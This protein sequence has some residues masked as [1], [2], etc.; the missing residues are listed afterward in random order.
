LRLKI[1]KKL[2]TANLNS[3]FPGS[4]KKSVLLVVFVAYN[5]YASLFAVSYRIYTGNS[6]SS[7]RLFT[8]FFI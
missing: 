7:N 3:E 2:G 8:L 1:L 5:R 4:Y 6:T